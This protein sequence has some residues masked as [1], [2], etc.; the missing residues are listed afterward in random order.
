[1]LEPN[2]CPAAAS[3]SLLGRPGPESRIIF[4]P[5]ARL[6]HVGE[7]EDTVGVAMSSKSGTKLLLPSPFASRE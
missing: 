2:L 1:M 6:F 7:A 4:P 5:P 3:C